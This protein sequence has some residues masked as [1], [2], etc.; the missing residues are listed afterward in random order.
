MKKK[1]H[2][3]TGE[4]S[5]DKIIQ[6]FAF[7]HEFREICLTRKSYTA[8]FSVTDNDNKNYLRALLRCQIDV[9]MNEVLDFQ[10][11]FI[12]KWWPKPDN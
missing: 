10:S 1:K 2:F 3:G 4:L 7:V 5:I 9:R 11:K 12:I 8:N 6:H